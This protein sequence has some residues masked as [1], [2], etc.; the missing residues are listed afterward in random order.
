MRLS[1]TRIWIV[2]ALGVMILDQRCLAFE[3]QGFGDVSV[4]GRSNN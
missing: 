1:F 2:M 3:F 4:V